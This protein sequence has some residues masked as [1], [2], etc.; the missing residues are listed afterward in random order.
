MHLMSFLVESTQAGTATMD[1]NVSFW[2]SRVM[3]IVQVSLLG[4]CTWIL[5][6]ARDMHKK[7]LAMW[8]VT[9]GRPEVKEDEGLVGQ[10][11][12]TG[13][14]IGR[15]DRDLDRLCERAGIERA[16]PR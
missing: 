3:D 9:F 4:V 8:T 5:A 10:V 2:F 15:I 1:H 14:A 7:V 11:R 6:L 13:H 16:E 12:D